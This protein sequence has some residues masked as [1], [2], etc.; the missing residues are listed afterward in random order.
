MKLSEKLNNAEIVAVL[1]QRMENGSRFSIRWFSF[2]KDPVRRLK[3]YLMVDFGAAMSGM[4][5]ADWQRTS[6]Q[7]LKIVNQKGGK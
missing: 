3:I 1:R 4:A 2:L 7:I 6:K 5:D